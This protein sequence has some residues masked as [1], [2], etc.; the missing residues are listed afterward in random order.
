MSQSGICRALARGAGAWDEKRWQLRGCGLG[1]QARD[2]CGMVLGLG[3][4]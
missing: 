1:L 3:G 2:G 4:C